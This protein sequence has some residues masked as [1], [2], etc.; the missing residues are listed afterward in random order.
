MYLSH[1]FQVTLLPFLFQKQSDE[2]VSSNYESAFA[3][4]AV[5][6]G[7]WA[8]IPEVGDLILAH[9]HALCPYIV[10]Y[11]VPREEGQSSEEYYK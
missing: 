6:V 4:A 3:I 10:P 5:C 7:V 8:L 2:Q 11:Y 9:F 1:I